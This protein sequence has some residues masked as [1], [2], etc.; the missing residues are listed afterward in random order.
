NGVELELPGL[1]DGGRLN[2]M[3]ASVKIGVHSVSPGDYRFQVE[4]SFEGSH[5]PNAFPEFKL[6]Q[7]RKKL[8]GEGRLKPGKQ[9]FTSTLEKTGRYKL[10][11]RAKDQ[12]W[13]HV[14]LHNGGWNQKIIETQTL[15]NQLRGNSEI[16]P[17][18]IETLEYN[19]QRNKRLLFEAI[20]ETKWLGRQ[21][22]RTLH[23]AKSMADGHDAISQQ[24]GDFYRAYRSSFDGNLQHYSV[25]IPPSYDRR[26]RQALVI[27]LHGIGS[28]THYTLRRVLG[29][30]RDYE[31]KEIG[32]KALIRTNMPRL[33][34]YGVITACPWSYHNS[35]YWFYG[36][37]DILRIIEE[38]KAAYRIDPNRV[39]LTGLSLGGLGTYH[40][41]HHYPDQFAALGPLGGFSSIKLYRQIGQHPKKWWEKVLIEQRDATTYAENGRHTPMK[42]VHGAQDGPRHARAMT[43]RYEA[44]GYKHELDIPELGHDVWQYSYGRG[45]LIRWMKKYKR[46]EFPDRVTFKTHS[47]RYTKAYWTQINWINNYQ[48][49]AILDVQVAK[50]GRH[51][52]QV[53]KLDNIRGFT[54]DL[55]QLKLADG[56]IDIHL[57]PAKKSFAVASATRVHFQKN[58][59]GHWSIAPSS[60]PPRGYKHAGV[61]GPLD[62][63]MFAPH[64]FI[65]G[66]QDPEQR[67]VNTLLAHEDAGYLRHRNHDIFFPLL[68]DS[69]PAAD[70]ALK[71]NIV[72]YGNPSSNR[73]LKKVLATG[74]LPIRFER[75]AIIVGKK[76]YSGKDVGI[77]M[78]FPNPFNPNSYVV[79]VAG[80]TWRGTLLSRHLPR[81]LPDIVVYDQQIDS[82]YLERILIDRPVLYAD[83]FTQDWKLPN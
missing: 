22:T 57:A 62:D 12:K 9:S 51:R 61:S 52:I 24:R 60:S 28:G 82:R 83:F 25:H 7:G 17:A 43:K 14:V 19:L 11:L 49:A 48:Q 47:Y 74:K 70:K 81:H 2:A 69:S 18:A 55:T 37:M 64:T 75:D 39:Y 63:I 15:L 3:A 78:I 10:K 41:G 59:N 23:W 50:P 32:G 36:E 27:G 45:A 72:L 56:D 44:L 16:T 8:I 67:S 66:T 80:T 79:I 35:A 40:V 1:K 58:N 54:L 20:P 53:N 71:G 13:E 33:P 29:K 77:K 21:I 42:V 65:I 46:P 30:D 34:D 4:T 38:M 31:N 5:V 73:L 26:K 76:R 6:S 68:L